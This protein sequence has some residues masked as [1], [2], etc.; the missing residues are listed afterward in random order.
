MKKIILA[1]A[2]AA[3]ALLAGNA[4][5]VTPMVGYVNTKDHVDI[6]N[7]A[8]V[9]IGA[10]RVLSEESMFNALEIGLLQSGN[11]DYENNSGDTKI[12]QIF[13]NAVK[14]YKLNDS[15][16]LSALAGLGYEYISN[17][18]L[19]NESDPFFNYGVGAAY[20]FANDM[21][22]KLDVRHQLKF[23]GDK[24]IVTLLGLA[25]PFGGKAKKEVELDG[26]ND[27][28]V[29]SMDRCPTSKAGV[30]V[31]ANGCEIDSDN[32]G[33][34]DSMDNCLTTPKGEA[35]N[36]KGCPIVVAVP[37]SADLGILFETNSAK[38]KSSDMLKFEKFTNYLKNVPSAKVV[39]EAHTD[40]VGNAHYNLKLSQKR[41]NS[42]KAQL[43][44]M[45]ISQERITAI[46]YGETKPL[47]ENNSAENMQK[48]R[49]V[50]ARIEK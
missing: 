3:T 17:Q 34:V 31:D 20:T 42:T 30:T 35:V 28:V 40:S 19:G 39:L 6:E 29:D 26:D 33:V 21:A 8:V 36:E 1:S 38:I 49:R 2:V 7:H 16:K 25:I 41:A 13:Y 14:D 11:A 47:V 4:Y 27:G 22:L 44:S 18:K 5:E 46:G 9:G 24:N 12:T 32:D 48:N 50:T 37:A 45:G 43:V 15:F 23:D 10:S